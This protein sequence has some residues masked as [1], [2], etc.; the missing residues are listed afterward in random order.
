MRRKMKMTDPEYQEEL[1]EDA[2][3]YRVKAAR[4]ATIA[5]LL[6]DYDADQ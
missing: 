1:L 3:R 4:L 5:Q 2:R 6:R